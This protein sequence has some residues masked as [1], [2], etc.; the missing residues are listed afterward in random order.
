MQSALDQVFSEPL[1]AAMPQ[2]S[3]KSHQG[4]PS[5][6]PALY[7]GHE[8]CK[9]TTALGLRAALHLERVRSRSTGKERDTES[10]NDYFGARYYAS[11]MGRMM[12]P[13]PLGGS[14]LNP[15]SLNRYAYV[16]NNPLIYTDPSGEECV[17]DD[18]SF[19]SADDKQTGSAG[20]CSG[21]GGT[22]VNP[23]LFENA[24]LTNGQWNSNYGDW[25]GQANSNLAQNWASAA[26]TSDAT[27]QDSVT[28]GATGT[29]FNFD[30]NF[31]YS[32]PSVTGPQLK[33]W[34][35]T[36]PP[37][38]PDLSDCL[39]S[40]SAAQEIHAAAMQAWS[41]Q[42][43]LPSSTSSPADD[44]GGEGVA[45]TYLTTTGSRTFYV[46][47]TPYNLKPSPLATVPNANVQGAAATNA[48]AALAAYGSDVA[49]CLAGH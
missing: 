18:G 7:L 34:N 39:S 11:S 44:N 28:V 15:Q 41:A 31:N 24:M 25:S 43:G 27:P 32:D 38:P 5:S 9:S 6:N 33:A 47:N 49:H 14:I 17:W 40:P 42:N 13:D 8:V 45:G 35:L 26:V 20:G 22:W 12:S 29:Q 21:Q 30:P 16:L 37:A 36:P 23:D 19:D 4:V 1:L 48:A 3:E 2:L 46:G 10:G